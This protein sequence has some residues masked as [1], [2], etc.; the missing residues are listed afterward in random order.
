MKGEREK[1][2]EDREKE[3]VVCD[4]SFLEE[5]WRQGQCGASAGCLQRGRGVKGWRVSASS[6]ETPIS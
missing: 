5:A 4:L 6:T 2:I 1:N 3:R